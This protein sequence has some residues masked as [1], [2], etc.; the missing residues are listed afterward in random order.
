V[1]LNGR[2]QSHRQSIQTSQVPERKPWGRRTAR[3][4][5]QRKTAKKMLHARKKSGCV[6]LEM[7]RQ[8]SFDLPAGKKRQGRCD[9]EATL[10][11]VIEPISDQTSGFDVRCDVGIRMCG[12]LTCKTVM[13][14]SR[15]QSN[16]VAIIANSPQRKPDGHQA[17]DEPCEEHRGDA[18]RISRKIQRIDRMRCRLD[19]LTQSEQKPS[20]PTDLT[21]FGPDIELSGGHENPDRATALRRPLRNALN[22]RPVRR[23]GEHVVDEQARIAQNEDTSFAD[24]A[25]QH[26]GATGDVVQH[27]AWAVE[28]LGM[29]RHHVVASSRQ[30]FGTSPPGVEDLR[31]AQVTKLRRY[32]NDSD[33]ADPKVME[34]TI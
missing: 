7:E 4:Q 25:A 18:Q 5:A 26:E 1:G 17:K 6:T 13:I 32:V 20:R 29:I 34:E 28:A 21:R 23:K 11:K 15:P 16:P 19:E 10:Q 22:K 24:R 14:R 9:V 33:F 27:V 2:H 8:H 3:L 30:N 12:K 31:P